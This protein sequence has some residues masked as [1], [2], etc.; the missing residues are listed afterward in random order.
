MNKNQMNLKTEKQ[1]TQRQKI[2]NRNM[3]A[4][5]NG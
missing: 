2:G 1:R 4:M 3:F 5:K